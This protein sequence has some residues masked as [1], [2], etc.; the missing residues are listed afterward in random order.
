MRGALRPAWAARLGRSNRRRCRREAPT[1]PR[2]DWTLTPTGLALVDAFLTA[3]ALWKTSD[4]IAA[5]EQGLLA[6]FCRWILAGRSAEA[7]EAAL[8]GLTRADVLA[9]LEHQLEPRRGRRRSLATVYGRLAAVRRLY[10]W[11]VDTGHVSRNPVPE[12]RRPRLRLVPRT[13]A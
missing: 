6:P 2:P 11:L 3:M 8:L 5:G 12:E 10:R 9:Y 13:Q 1:R 7:A 4:E